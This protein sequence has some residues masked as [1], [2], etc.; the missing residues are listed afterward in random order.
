MTHCSRMNERS[1][2]ES[3]AA[4]VLPQQFF[5]DGSV[6][7]FD[8]WGVFAKLLKKDQTENDVGSP[9]G[10]KQRAGWILAGNGHAEH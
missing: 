7:W 3:A 8:N 10:E 5:I 6:H 4:D 9:G 2:F 1:S